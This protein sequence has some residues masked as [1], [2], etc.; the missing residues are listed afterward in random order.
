MSFP[1]AACAPFLKESIRSCG[2][3]VAGANGL[4]RQSRD[5]N[6]FSMYHEYCKKVSGRK[7]QTPEVYWRVA[8]AW[9]LR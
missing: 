7:V 8:F 2:A 9:P 5:G 4:S 6:V 1:C 3:S